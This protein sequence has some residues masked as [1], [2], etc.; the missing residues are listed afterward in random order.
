LSRVALGGV[1]DVEAGDGGDRDDDGE[2]DE[3]QVHG[4]SP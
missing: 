4:G 2:E 3:Q 1:V